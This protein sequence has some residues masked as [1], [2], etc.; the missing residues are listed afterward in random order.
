MRR[1][2]LA[3]LCAAAVG[4]ASAVAP[5]SG[6]TGQRPPEQLSARSPGGGAASPASLPVDGAVA[7]VRGDKLVVVERGA[8]RTVF[9]AQPG[10]VIRDPAFSPDGRSIAFAYT[11]PRPTPRPDAPVAEQPRSSDVLLVD[12]D[13]GNPRVGVPHGDP[14]VVLE[15]PA[16]SADSR[17][18]I[19][20]Y[21]SSSHAGGNPASQ[22]I[23]LRSRELASGRGATIARNARQAAVSRDGKWIVYAAYDAGRGTSLRIAPATDGDE[24]V[25]VPAGRLPTLIAPRFSP[26]GATVVF[27]AVTPAPPRRGAARASAPLEW[28]E[29]LVVATPAYAHGVPWEVWSVPT[30][31]GE[32]RQLTTLAEDRPAAAWSP[33]GRRLLVRG[34]EALYLLH[35]ASGAIETV[36][37]DGSNTGIDWRAES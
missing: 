8:A 21:Y 10:G 22:T 6:P 30:E 15:A 23:E 3:M 9:A 13:G 20:D 28:L 14:G 36:E 4:C 34:E 35:V 16:W 5:S 17:S 29:R 37:R 26:D 2:F 24:R 7:Y 19:Y 25:L 12:A 18:L 31:G 32:L 1:L 11:P 27:S 33:D